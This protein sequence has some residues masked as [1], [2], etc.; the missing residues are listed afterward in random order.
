M[1]T[2]L[3]ITYAVLLG[4]GGII[5]YKKAGSKMSLISGLLSSTLICLALYLLT[6]DPFKGFLLAAIVSCLLETVFTLRLIKTKKFMPSGL[7]MILSL[8][9]FVVCLLKIL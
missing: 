1:E 3:L 5:G 4:V 2:T 6:I 8:I 7:L 9:V